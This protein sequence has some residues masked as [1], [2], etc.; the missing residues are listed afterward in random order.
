MAKSRKEIPYAVM[1]SLIAE[2]AG[3]FYVLTE[4]PT[5]GCHD[6]TSLIV[7]SRY[8]FDIYKMT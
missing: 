1:T 8:K 3:L 2:D 7:V 5:T 6:M 4:V